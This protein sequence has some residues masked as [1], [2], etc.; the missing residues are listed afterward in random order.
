MSRLRSEFSQ[1]NARPSFSGLP[2][3]TRSLCPKQPGTSLSNF[4]RLFPGQ[5]LFESNGQCTTGTGRRDTGFVLRT[6][7][8]RP[9]SLVRGP[10]ALPPGWVAEVAEK[11][12]IRRQ[13]HARVTG[14]QAV[15]IGLHGSV[16]REKIRIAPVG[17]GVDAVA[18]GVALA[19]RLLA[20]RLGFREQHGHVAIRLG[21]DLLRVLASLGAELGGLALTLGL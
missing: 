11:A 17:V 19:A 14:V 16:E 6:E 2:A 8:E 12:R 4:I 5:K 20:L 15:F 9:R 1:P 18:L 21:A 13:Q 3:K 10:L 7:D